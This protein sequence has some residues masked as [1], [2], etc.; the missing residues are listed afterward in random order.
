MQV[1]EHLARFRTI[2]FVVFLSHFLVAQTYPVKKVDSLLTTGI[3]QIIN[4]NYSDA[5][6]TFSFLNKEYPNLP[7]GRIYLSATLIAKS[8]DL[9]LPFNKTLIDSNLNEAIKISET[10]LDKNKSAWNI[11]FVALSKGYLAYFEAINKDWLSAL[12]DGFESAKYFDKCLAKD[13]SFYDCYIA[14]GTFEYWKSEKTEFM[15]WLPFFNN[16]SQEG[17]KLLTEAIKH[18]S[19]NRYIGIYSLQWILVYEKKYQDV[20]NL[21]QKVLKEYPKSRFFKWALARAYEEIDVKKSITIYN[22]ILD[23]YKKDT[24]TVYNKILLEHLLAQQYAKIA[25]FQKSLKLCNEILDI[26]NLTEHE[27]NILKRRLD[28]VKKLKEKLLSEIKTN[29]NK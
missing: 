28:R 21:S 12:N 26:P 29:N 10:R 7:F 9:K 16:E 23:S 2:L 8:F 14:L 19:Y 5:E 13:S 20:I 11:Y 25:E 1:I 18:A 27:R 17:I 3:N 6:N 24:L 4:E 22:E 15:Q